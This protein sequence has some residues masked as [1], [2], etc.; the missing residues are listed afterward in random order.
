[1]SHGRSADKG[2]VQVLLFGGIALVVIVVL[3]R[4]GHLGM[5]FF[6]ARAT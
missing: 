1:M 6:L 2:F 5:L 3:I 4:T